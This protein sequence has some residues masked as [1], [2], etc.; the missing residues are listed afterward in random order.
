M[1]VI[2]VQ[3]VD[4]LGKSGEKV[5]VKDGY[6]RNF[7]IPQGWAIPATRGAGNQALAQAAARVRAAQLKKGKAS[8]L[9]QQLSELTCTIEVSLG[10][11]GKLHGAVTAADIAQA[12]GRQGIALDKHQ[13]DLEKPLTI[14]G[15]T[16]VPVHLHPGVK[17]SIRV[18][19][20][21]K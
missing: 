14:L 13:I 18:S 20:V 16:Q 1:N 12:L 5:R 19:L 10:A 7:L 2:L 11:Q 8:E 15:D 6:G 4:R 21:S 17:A 3:D 9:A